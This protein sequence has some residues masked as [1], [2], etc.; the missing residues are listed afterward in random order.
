MSQPPSASAFPFSSASH[1]PDVVGRVREHAILRERLA[2]TLAGQGATVLI[3][4]V[5]GVGKTVLVEA[6][7]RE[8]VAQGALWLTGHCYD[9]TEMTP[10]S[11]WTEVFAHYPAPAGFPPL[12]PPFVRQGTLG[13]VLNTATLF[14]Q[15]GG[16]FA[17][18]TARQPVLLLLEDVHL[19]DSASLDLLRFLVR[20]AVSLPLLIV[21]TYRTEEVAAH[22]PL[23]TL[24]PIIVREAQAIRLG[25]RPIHDEDVRALVEMRYHLP[26]DDLSRLVM[27]VQERAQGNPFFVT[28]VLYAIEEEGVLAASD[29][30]WT[31]GVLAQIGVPALLQ[32]VIEQR[33]L[34]VETDSRSLLETAAVIGQDVSLDLWAAITDT[35]EDTLL[36]AVAV[37]GAGVIAET[38]DGVRAMFAHAL[39]RAVLYEGI[40]PSRRRR[41]HRQI[42]DTLIA[43]TNPDPDA[44]AYH[45]RLANDDRAAYWL[46]RAGERA[47][48][49]FANLIAAERYTTALVLRTNAGEAAGERGW[50]L[51]GIARTR[52]YT[53]PRDGILRCDEALQIAAET[54]DAALAAI[55][56]RLR[57]VLRCYARVVRQGLQDMEAAIEAFRDLTPEDRARIR[58]RLHSSSFGD[59]DGKGTY[60]AW[61]GL[62]GRATEVLALSEPIIEA[63]MRSSVLQAQFTDGIVFSGLT[64][65]Y[66]MLGDRARAQWASDRYR[67]VNN[68][69]GDFIQV[70]SAWTYEM[71][72]LHLPFDADRQDERNRRVRGTEEARERLAGMMRYPP[73]YGLQGLL[74]IEG[75]WTEIAT[76]TQAMRD[77]GMQP[78]THQA[79]AYVPGPLARAQGA[80]ERAW[81]IVREV[82]PAGP[83]TAPGD[84]FF[85][86]VLPVLRLAA[87]LSTDAGD[88]PEAR[89][90]LEAHDRWLHWNG[91][92]QGRTEGMLGWEAYHA[93]RGDRT[94]A[95]EAATAAVGLA[96][97]PRQPLALLAAQRRLGLWEAR[98]K[99][100]PA[101]A[102]YLDAALSLATACAAPYERALTLIVAAEM[103]GAMG[104]R[105]RAT[106][107]LSEARAICVPLRAVLALAQADALAAALGAR[108]LVPSLPD[109]LTAREVDVLRLIAAGM[110]NRE[111]ADTLTISGRTV[112]RHISNIY[113]KTGAHG[114]AEAAV[115]ALRHHLAEH[116]AP[117][118]S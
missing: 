36:F 114:K 115:Y 53:D 32:Q 113:A 55:T 12:P 60:L 39:V 80:T 41:L 101:A 17:A 46:T 18:L 47:E 49:A 76:I 89:S 51:N 94:A 109:G 78:A 65:V 15:L 95:H 54:G 43:Q 44:V 6:L 48:R 19:A 87:A 112:D 3:S 64:H 96:M 56:L 5:A 42:A 7:G 66:A 11:P 69:I 30:A 99:H 116:T 85:L 16:F 2:T 45:L 23:Y 93:A 28:E 24:L 37:A 110:S 31:L 97:E 81:T 104:D 14:G 88:F 38:Q 86:D 91:A 57:G 117:P 75:A 102:A 4:G 26:P 77:A 61:L 105:E 62:V 82:F 118:L 9:R 73:H 1:V 107:A 20:M 40:T 100:Y 13:A 108:L 83:T 71:L 35:D 10:Y 33:L 84:V 59:S 72:V 90:W 34:R 92:V 67:E 79:W 70:Q 74:F 103:H 111:I 8:A 98:A 29:D 52:R 22:H 27:H 25:L 50:L 58:E 68:V 63:A 106:E 21:V